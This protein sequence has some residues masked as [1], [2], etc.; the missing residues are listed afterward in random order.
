MSVAVHTNVNAHPAGDEESTPLLVSIRAEN[1]AL[2]ATLPPPVAALRRRRHAEDHTVSARMA[3]LLFWRVG[4]LYGA[5]AV[6]LGAFG[7]HGLKN[8]ISDPQKLA[9]WSTAA[10]YQLAHSVVLLA[11]RGHPV[12]ATFFTAGMTMFSGSIYALTLDTERF[13]WMGPVTPLGGLCLI[14][15]WLS[16]AFTRGAVRF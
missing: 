12:A 8:R 2:T 6:A 5:T 4:A 1:A 10:H 7:A 15:G 3:G 16:L 14:L 9:N 13:K 11:T